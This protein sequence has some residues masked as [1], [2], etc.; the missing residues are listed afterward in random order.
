LLAVL[1]LFAALVAG[2]GGDDPV[3]PGPPAPATFRKGV[4]V[5]PRSITL[6]DIQEFVERADEAGDLL[7]W[8]S[9]WNEVNGD[10][11]S[12]SSFA[13][14]LARSEGF[15]PV[16][17]AAFY[18]PET[19]RLI[20]P[21]TPLVLASYKSGAVAFA[22]RHKPPYLALGID[23]NLVADAL[24]ADFELYVD[25]FSETYDAVKAVS[26]NTKVFLVF[27]LEQLKGLRG[28]LFGGVNDTTT[29][30]WDLLDRFPK[31]DLFGFA[32]YPG[33]IY[34]EP[35]EIPASYYAEIATRTSK[36]IAITELGWSA[37]STIAGW[38]SDDAEQAE[39]VARFFE[40]VEP[41][42]DRTDMVIWTFLFDQA[43]GD[44]FTGIGLRRSDGSARP[45]WD[46]W[47]EAE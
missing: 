38:E 7:A 45:S 16:V 40:L 15:V 1:A 28:G 43:F 3:S 14:A 44:P 26:P 41:L 35:S 8:A 18:N 10:S 2:C 5:S 33:L 20:L 42:R 13:F 9:A 24:P 6:A 37:N 30:R 23:V 32:S 21:L 25:L 11:S 22:E 47:L 27:Q 4:S 29:A 19:G 34:K 12:L 36:P 17:E 46:A 31:A 39:F